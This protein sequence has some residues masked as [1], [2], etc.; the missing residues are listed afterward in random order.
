[1]MRAH[2]IYRL[3]ALIKLIVIEDQRI[4]CYPVYR[5]DIIHYSLAST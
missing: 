4:P 1:M 5:L 2:V 3:Y